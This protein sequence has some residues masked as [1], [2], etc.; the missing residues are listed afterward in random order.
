ML[1]I[2]SVIRLHAATAHSAASAVVA[3][4]LRGQAR[5]RVVELDV[6][7]ERAHLLDQNVE[8]LRDAGLEGVVA[9]DDRFVDLGAAG[10]VVRLH[11][12][13]FL[14]GVGGA[15]GFKRPHLHFAEALSAE[16]RL[17]AQ[18]LLGD[19]AVR[20]DRTGV[21]LVVHQMMQLQHVDVADRHSTIERLAG[22]AVVKLRLTRRIEAR[23]LQQ[24]DDVRFA[25]A[26][27]HRRRDRHAVAQLGGKLDHA[28]VVEV[29]DILVLAVAAVDLLQHVAK[30]LDLVVLLVGL[31]HLADLQAHAGAGPSEMGLENL[32]DVH[33][34]RHAERI[35]D[36]VDMGPV[37]EIRHVLDRHD[38]ATR[39][40]C[41]RDGRPSCRRTGSCASPRRRP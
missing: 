25:G 27:E 16:L 30:R 12:Q 37:L 15:I 13:H 3:A 10:N 32:A 40:P 26:V 9:A 20:S 41:C 11:G 36:D 8:T 7:A 22:T 34:A 5:L 1:N 33:P 23:L 19:Q 14:Q 39:R 38:P 6:E 29:G 24:F 31:D 2:G 35:E 4:R 21:D 17:A 28:F 18:R